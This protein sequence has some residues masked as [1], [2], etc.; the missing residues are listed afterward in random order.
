MADTENTTILDTGF[1]QSITTL[2]FDPL[3]PVWGIIIGA[4]IY[5]ALLAVL[6]MKG[7]T[8]IWL[9]AVIM[10]LFF[11]VLLNPVSITETRKG[12]KNVVLVLLDETQ[13][14]SVPPRT[15]Q[16]QAA[17]EAL[18]NNID[19]EERLR[20]QSIRTRHQYTD[21]ED[22]DAFQETHIYTALKDALANMDKSRLGAVVIIS[23]GQ[24]HDI[25]PMLIEGS[26]TDF[27][28]HKDLSLPQGVPIHG[29]ITGTA[30]E[31]DRQIIIENTP[32]YGITGKEAAIDIRIEVSESL[33][34]VPVPLTYS[35]NGNTARTE[36]I[37]PHQS[38]RI[39]VPIEQ[40][41][42]NIYQFSIPTEDGELSTRNN[43]KVVTINGVRDR[44]QVLLV[45][46]K[47]NHGGR[48]WRD[49]LRSDASVDLVH[50]TILR[51]PGKVDRTPKEEMSL[52]EFPVRELFETKINNFDLIIFDRYGLT[53]LL[54]SRY[55]DNIHDFVANGG[56]LFM[57]I[58]PEALDDYSIFDTRIAD[59]LPAALT[60]GMLEE[61][62]TPSLS[63]LGLRH[64]V[65]S[66]MRELRV[67]PSSASAPPATDQQQFPLDVAP[68]FRQIEVEPKP[69]AQVL[70][71]GAQNQ[72]LLLLDRYEQGRVALL[73][74]DQLWLW[75]RG[76]H[77]AG[78]DRLFL[79]RSIHWLMKEPDLEENGL[80]ARVQGRQIRLIKRSL[81][82]TDIDITMTH[83][84]GSEETITMRPEGGEPAETIIQAD[85]AGIYKF[86]HKTQN[87]FAVVGD[88]NT[89]EQ[90]DL[91]STLEKLKPLINATGGYLNRVH[92]QG[93]PSLRLRE[94][95]S[96]TMSSLDSRFSGIS[97]QWMGVWNRK[98]YSIAGTKET[99]LL[100][101]L[102]VFL[103]IFLGLVAAWIIESRRSR[104]RS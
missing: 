90:T 44:L 79:K 67:Q 100:P 30:D 23:D 46:G 91:L 87:V 61:M 54:P 4:L 102:P 22:K 7:K 84:D 88:L 16:M 70:M 56:A 97:G 19:G 50:F 17:F 25:P 18:K 5:A 73:T 43:N 45:S 27:S 60:G 82:E 93:V 51:E 72:P 103:L 59:M 10:A 76:F 12:E 26:G 41:G 101:T 2:A 62:Y 42:H 9:R 15:A 49:I 37:P 28:L 52:I 77:K 63:R 80:Q 99:P 104:L 95:A 64:P 1:G 83:P 34:Q 38:R 74:G 3:V 71:R 81:E 68:W 69:T 39:M 58:G 8:S 21:P 92:N 94:S 48:M 35:I 86:T 89:P 40:A 11:L 33:A 31:A 57:A 6:W 85:E 96:N 75:A 14:Q 13:S 78:P 29:L 98:A 65:T 55:F 24:I 36:I 66:F 32:F 53:Y 47:P 20:L